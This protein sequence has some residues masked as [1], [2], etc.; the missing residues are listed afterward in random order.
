MLLQE[1][2]PADDALIEEEEKKF[3]NSK[4]LIYWLTSLP[5]F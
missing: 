3:L 1:C 5:I 2:Y 4:S